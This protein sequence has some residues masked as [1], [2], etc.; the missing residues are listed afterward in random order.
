MFVF[1]MLLEQQVA[2][3]WVHFDVKSHVL[4]FTEG[5]LMLM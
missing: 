4:V 2:V 1:I 5:Q 3:K